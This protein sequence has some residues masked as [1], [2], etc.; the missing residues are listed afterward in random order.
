MAEHSLSLSEIEAGG[1]R[2]YATVPG[3]KAG[4]VFSIGSLTAGDMIEWSEANE[5]EAKRTAGLRLITKSV[6]DGI[7]GKHEGAKGV[8]IMN[9]EHIAMLRKKPHRMTEDIVKGILRL[10]GMKVKDDAL[11]S[12]IDAKKG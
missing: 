1:Q 8:N 4:T 7:P 3:F 12:E 5:G 9:D 6:V 11:Q 2:E 10:N